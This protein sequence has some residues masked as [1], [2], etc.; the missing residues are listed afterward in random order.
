VLAAGDVAT[1]AAWNVLTNDVIALAAGPISHPSATYQWTRWNPT[2]VSG[3]DTAPSA[4]A[5]ASYANSTYFTLANSGG[6]LTVT[7]LAAGYYEV[8]VTMELLAAQAFTVF[9]GTTNFGGTSTKYYESTM[10][11]TAEPTTDNNSSS[12][13]VFSVLATAN[14]TLTIL[15]TFN[16][17]AGAAAANYFA[18]ASMFIKYLGV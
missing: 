18:E 11:C 12:C 4:T 9:R 2:N 10:S 14:Q 5:L 16:V 15:P 3:T 8:A 13:A 6:T 17:T 1:A 7:L